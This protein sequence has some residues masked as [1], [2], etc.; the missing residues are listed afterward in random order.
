M[1]L[2]EATSIYVRAVVDLLRRLLGDSLLGVYL[3][4][5]GAMGG[6]DPRT[7]DVDLAAVVTRSPSTERKREVVRS[8]SHTALPCP[9]R[10]LEL[11]VYG[12]KAA[13]GAA[14]KWELNLNT[15]PAV[16]VEASYAPSAQP[17]HWFVL[18]VAMARKHARPLFGPPPQTVFG[19]VR[20][21]SVLRALLGSIRWHRRNDPGG[22]QS[23]LNACRAWR[24]LEEGMWSSKPAAAR[25]ARA[26]A[27]DPAPIDAAV[28]ARGADGTAA[29]DEKAVVRFVAEVERRVE[30]AL[31]G[32]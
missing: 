20:R 9:V 30:R 27:N 13:G 18:D 17:H 25:W 10:K 14:P 26:R 2:D 24:W 21:D 6:F 4:G 11:V 3:V 19:E 15:G 29:V 5:S 1:F 7:S 32:G 12:A 23:V 16:G 31:E 8:L 22:N 28:A